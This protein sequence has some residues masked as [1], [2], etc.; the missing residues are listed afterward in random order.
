MAPGSESSARILPTKDSD[1]DR[2]NE[3]MRV[4][5]RSARPGSF[6]GDFREHNKEDY[7]MRVAKKSQR[8][9]SW[10]DPCEFQCRSG[11]CGWF[12]HHE[13]WETYQS[14]A[15]GAKGLSHIIGFGPLN[16][17]MSFCSP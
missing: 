12:S 10:A 5:E 8:I 7:M 2:T 3:Q 14:T 17:V 9:L 4:S 1:W 11:A 16:L 13:E 15:N 6:P